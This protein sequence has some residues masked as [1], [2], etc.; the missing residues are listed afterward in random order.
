M[1]TCKV[2]SRSLSAATSSIAS[3]A[4]AIALVPLTTAAAHPTQ[5][6]ASTARLEKVRDGA[7]F[8]TPFG[9]RPVHSTCA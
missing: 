3:A 2:M 5:A 9:G 1:G 7:D 4:L 8:Y 6:T